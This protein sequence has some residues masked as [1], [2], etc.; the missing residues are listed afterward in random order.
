MGF[1]E[2][3]DHCPDE[4]GDEWMSILARVFPVTEEGATWHG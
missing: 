1:A 4:L 3:V 2:R